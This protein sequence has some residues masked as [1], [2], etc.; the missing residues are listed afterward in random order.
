MNHIWIVSLCVL[1]ASGWH[2]YVTSRGMRLSTQQVR[3][4]KRS[5]NANPV[6][7]SQPLRRN[8]VFTLRD[9]NDL[10]GKLLSKFEVAKTAHESSIEN[11]LVFTS[12][13]DIIEVLSFSSS[14]YFALLKILNIYIRE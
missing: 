14:R 1:Y 7:S 13:I 2:N 10:D 6:N 12:R 4:R 11:S 9:S 5:D 8:Q 3:N